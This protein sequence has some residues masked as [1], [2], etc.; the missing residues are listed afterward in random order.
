M[1]A[2]ASPPQL[3]LWK[4]PAPCGVDLLQGL[5]TSC[6]GPWTP[7]PGLGAPWGAGAEIYPADRSHKVSCNV[8]HAW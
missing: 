6:E 3:W 5:S 2:S 4:D 1:R 7:N 8:N